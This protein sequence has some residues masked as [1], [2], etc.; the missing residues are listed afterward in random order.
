MTEKTAPSPF[1]KIPPRATRRAAYPPRRADVAT[2]QHRHTADVQPTRESTTEQLPRIKHKRR[3]W[4]LG[5]V[6]PLLQHR[7]RNHVLAGMIATFVFLQVMR[8]VV[9]PWF[10][11][12]DIHS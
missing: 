6:L 5:L 8:M 7:Y 2:E 3:G 1:T 9:V 12:P 10:S 4:F 11:V